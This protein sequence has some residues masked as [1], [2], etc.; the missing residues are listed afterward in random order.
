MSAAARTMQGRRQLPF[1][2]VRGGPDAAVRSV[3]R[4]VGVPSRGCSQRDRL[5]QRWSAAGHGRG[6]RNG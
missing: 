4:V 6:R 5:E 1:M 2:T 3:L